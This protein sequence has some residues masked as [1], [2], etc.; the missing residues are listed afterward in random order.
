MLRRHGMQKHSFYIMPIYVYL[1]FDVE[2][3]AVFLWAN[4]RSTVW[5]ARALVAMGR[6]AFLLYQ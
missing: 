4:L 1:K 6:Q 3:I 5:S 2:A